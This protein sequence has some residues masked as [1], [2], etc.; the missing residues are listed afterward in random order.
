[1]NVLYLLR[2]N[3]YV[4]ECVRLADILEVLFIAYV[5]RCYDWMQSCCTTVI[6]MEMM[7]LG[8]INEIPRHYS[9]FPVFVFKLSAHE[10]TKTSDPVWNVMYP[11]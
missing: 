3:H 4:N 10:C 7:C 8:N 1:M 6:Y 11:M 2:L 9:S 5:D